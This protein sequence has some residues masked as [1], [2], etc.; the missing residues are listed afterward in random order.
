MDWIK[1]HIWE[2]IIFGFVFGVLMID[3][4]PDFTFINKAADSIGYIYSAEYLYPSYHTS[5]PLYL[6][7]SHL[8]LMLPFGTE[9]W[10]M[11]LVSV[12]S[13]IGACIFIYLILRHQL[14]GKSNS[15]FYS[16][17]GVLIYGLSALVICQ[18]V[19]VNT[20]ATTCMLA[21][22]AYYFSI[23]KQW[24]LMALLL[25]VGLA[26]HLLSFFTFAVMFVAHKEYRKNWKA[27][28]ITFSFVVF[29]LYIPLT[30]R[31]PYMWLPSPDEVNTIWA[32]ITDTLSVINMLI[33]SL[34]IWDVPKR[35]FDIVGI[36]GISIG[37]I[38]IIPL[39]Y[40]FRHN[41]I[42]RNSLFWLILIPII[43]FFGELDM[44][45]FDYTMVAMPFLSVAICV[46][47]SLLVER[48]HFKAKVFAAATLAVVV[49][50]GAFNCWFFDIGQ[51]LDQGLSATKLYRE[52]FNKLPDN[53]IFMPNYAWEWEAIYKYNKDY[54]KN[55]YP[56]CI[57]ILPS[58]M[59]RKKLK[60][61][62]INLTDSEAK[63]ISIKA[64]EVAKSI[65]ELNDNVWT[66]Q[67]YDARTF[68]TAV[69]ATNHNSNLVA[70]VDKERIK[71]IIENP[72]IQWMPYNPYEIFTTEIF[73]EKWG[74]C[75]YSTWNVRVFA[76][77]I[78]I[79]LFLNWIFWRLGRR[80]K[81]DQI[82]DEGD[83]S[84]ERLG[85]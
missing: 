69:V 48:Y 71:Q 68:G 1:K 41:K 12:L 35:I 30:N 33:G 34:A 60:E 63:N 56:I 51:N 52:E 61:D 54:D 20:Y 17:L 74:Y 85:N 70:N 2:V 57:D 18:S 37:V 16:L 72:Q 28:L 75:L 4:N 47:L 36:I 5:P 59:Y 10:R 55:I 77:L 45:T 32:V 21:A 50:L 58:D 53:A 62:G 39:V 27:L 31:E 3:L 19:I 26:V 8:F 65:V 64:S 38:T 79:G 49:G 24:K 25:G 23:R 13:T 42:W 76:S 22:G 15:K 46:G 6:L 29:Y 84:G 73:I 81:N 7:V 44:N 43:V 82:V 66:T 83:E 40:Y 11:G 14:N 67:V 78:V 80:G 9:A